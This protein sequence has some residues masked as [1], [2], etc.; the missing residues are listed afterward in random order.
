MRLRFIGC[1]SKRYSFS[2]AAYFP[3]G[4]TTRHLLLDIT[5]S[6]IAISSYTYRRLDLGVPKGVV[7]FIARV[8]LF[9]LLGESEVALERMQRQER[10][11]VCATLRQ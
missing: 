3:E 2:N 9:G 7:A 4:A 1:S 6:V 8:D 10:L 5:N 11:H